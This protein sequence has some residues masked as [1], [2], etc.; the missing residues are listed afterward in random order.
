MISYIFGSAS[1]IYI[2]YFTVSLFFLASPLNDY[3]P[4]LL[5]LPLLELL[6]CF[7]LL[8]I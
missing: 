2:T 3:F 4:I 7:I 1:I 5:Y 8:L 6:F